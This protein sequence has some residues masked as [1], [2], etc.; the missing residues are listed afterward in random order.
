MASSALENSTSIWKQIDD[1]Q[2]VLFR[3]DTIQQA[4][5]TEQNNSAKASNSTKQEKSAV[6]PK[7]KH[8]ADANTP[9]YYTS[10]KLET[11]GS[12]VYTPA[13]FGIIHGPK[14]DAPSTIAV[15][16]GSTMHEFA[17]DELSCDLTIDTLITYNNVSRKDKVIIPVNATAK[18]LIEKTE[19][20]LSS[21]T[22]S[23]TRVFLNGVEL[24]RGSD[25][26]EKMGINSSSRLVVLACLS[27][28]VSVNRFGI[29]YTG[30]CY[31]ASSI[32]GISFTANKDIR[33][34]GFGI[35]CSEKGD[36][37]YGTARFVKGPDAKGTALATKEVTIVPQNPGDPE[38]KIYKC[39]F[40]RPML[41]K[42]GDVHSCVVEIK[43]GSSHYGSS[44]MATVTENQEGRDIT[45]TFQACNG[46]SNGTG[47]ASGQIPEVYYYA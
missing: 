18:D 33:V 31:S 4:K 24:Q 44:G 2:W 13:G 35:Y 21:Q 5:A 38:S 28:P 46:S 12:V 19:Q 37:L 42:G 34:V 15:K 30:W 41:V 40:D 10:R 3:G 14:P 32:D 1:D 36:A 26:L 23:M 43:G 29:V 9:F 45:F 8:L 39:M 27:N 25:S 6:N 17:R 16:V 11:K 22:N 7:D 20:M 47:I